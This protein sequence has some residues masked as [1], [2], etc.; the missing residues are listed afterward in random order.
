MLQGTVQNV[1]SHVSSITGTI[2]GQGQVVKLRSSGDLQRR[3][4]ETNE[5]N[6]NWPVSSYTSISGTRQQGWLGS[7]APK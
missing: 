2:S 4:Y 1:M 7:L 3:S 6:R 5:P